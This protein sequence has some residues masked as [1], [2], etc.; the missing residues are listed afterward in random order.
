M[1]AN[2]GGGRC[3]CSSGTLYKELNL[4]DVINEVKT[5]VSGQI[6]EKQLKLQIDA[7]NVRDE[8]VYCDKTRLNQVLLNL[9]SN[10]IK[11]TPVGGTVSLKLKQLGAV[12][13]GSGMYE[14]RV[15][16]N[17]IGM[18]DELAAIPIL[19]MT[20]NVFD[21]DRKQAA[22]YG[23]DGFLSKPIVIDELINTLQ[24]IV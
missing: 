14:I 19:V 4:S 23:M 5:I 1:S 8:D 15:K 21:E 10:A 11:F 9:L 22:E 20:A 17:G 12:Q 18:S 16:D 13:N 6:N 24:K 7:A 2:R 3:T